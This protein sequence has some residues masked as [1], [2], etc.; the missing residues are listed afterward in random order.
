M[1]TKPNPFTE[2]D[3]FIQPD[4]QPEHLWVVLEKWLKS[5]KAVA[6]FQELE[7]IKF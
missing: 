4:R 3:Y 2:K 6:F 1:K 7:Q 5:K